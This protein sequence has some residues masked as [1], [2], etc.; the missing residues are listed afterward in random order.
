MIQRHKR[1]LIVLFIVT[2]LT[3]LLFLLY[4]GQWT[5]TTTTHSSTTTTSSPPCPSIYSQVVSSTPLS[6]EVT[7]TSTTTTRQPLK[8]IPKPL[9]KFL[10]TPNTISTPILNAFEKRFPNINVRHVNSFLQKGFLQRNLSLIKQVKQSLTR[11]PSF[12]LESFASCSTDNYKL[13]LHGGLYKSC[14]FNNICLTS[15]GK[16]KLFMNSNN[17]LKLV[18][19]LTLENVKRKDI[20]VETGHPEKRRILN[21]QL[22]DSTKQHLVCHTA[23]DWL[24]FTPQIEPMIEFVEEEEKN[25]KG[26]SAAATTNSAA[27]NTIQ[28]QV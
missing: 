13:P 16:W 18:Q 27:T 20:F 14:Q 22:F 9:L 23:W 25:S 6:K 7:T 19:Q 12:K 21:P 2:I 24:C 26:S 11:S 15:S 17:A 28:Q 4:L 1:T 3:I 8:P 10:Q 5:P